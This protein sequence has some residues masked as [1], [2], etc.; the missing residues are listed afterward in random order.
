MCVHIFNRRIIHWFYVMGQTWLSRSSSDLTHNVPP[1]CLHL[2]MVFLGTTNI[3]A[4]LH[5]FE[6]FSVLKVNFKR[7]K[8]FSTS[9]SDRIVDSAANVLKCQVDGL[10]TTYLVPRAI[11][12]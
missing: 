4:I 12:F 5:C 9:C 2:F 8:N 10:P 1:T 3:K 11:L 7:N 6:A